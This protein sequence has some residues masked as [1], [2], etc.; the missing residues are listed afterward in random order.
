MTEQPDPNQG[1]A[2]AAP[3]ETRRAFARH[4]LDEARSAE[5]A[6]LEPHRLILLIERLRGGLDDMLRLVDEITE[7][8]PRPPDDNQ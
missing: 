8:T 1:R 4:T 6:T 7:P 3:Q 2:L 5:L